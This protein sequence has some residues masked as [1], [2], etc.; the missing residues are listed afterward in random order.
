MGLGIAYVQCYSMIEVYFD[1]YR[2]LSFGVISTS[3]GVGTMVLPPLII[4]SEEYFGWRGCML[5]LSGICLHCLVI[6]AIFRPVDHD[7]EVITLDVRRQYRK[8]DNCDEEDHLTTDHESDAKV[9]EMHSIPDIEIQMNYTDDN[10]EVTAPANSNIEVISRSTG[11]IE[12]TG[13]SNSN[14]DDTS[15]YG[16]DMALTTPPR[17][18]MEATTRS[19]MDINTT[20]RSCRYIKM[21]SRSISEMTNQ[22][23]SKTP[24]KSAWHFIQ[25]RE[26][27]LLCISVFFVNVPCLLTYIH[28]PAYFVQQGASKSEIATQL[29]ILGVCNV[30]SRFIGG[31]ATNN[32]DIDPLLLYISSS[33]IAG[34]LLLV[35]PLLSSTYAGQVTFSALFGFYSS[36]CN[37]MVAPVI[38]K[39][40]GEKDFTMAHGVSL[41]FGGIGALVGPPIA[42]IQYL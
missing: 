32:K 17:T 14:M 34:I 3:V 5:I 15:R 10:L 33:G 25:N 40:V 42:G 18:N 37:S 38:V 8:E 16:R 28:Y 35:C 36:W 23:N 13:I 2:N 19:D 21:D 27:V 7:H 22:I 9:I 39:C 31:V 20:T 6:G 4:A 26:F 12:V 24:N 11:N 41:A 29:T 30:I 1:K